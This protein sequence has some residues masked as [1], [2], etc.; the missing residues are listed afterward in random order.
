M[1]KIL[2][3]LLFAVGLFFAASVQTVVN[4]YYQASA[5]ENM[6]RF[7]STMDLSE[8][9]ADDISSM[10]TII[11]KIWDNYDTDYFSIRNFHYTQDGDYA[12]AKYT[13]NASISGAED[14]TY[15]LDYV[16][17]LHYTQG[18]WKVV[19]VKP[20][21]E[22]LDE[23]DNISALLTADA[24]INLS[25]EDYESD[26]SKKEPSFTLD[27]EEMENLDTDLKADLYSCKSD[28]YCQEK[29]WG[30]CENGKCSAPPK[31]ESAGG[32]ESDGVC[33]GSAGLVALAGGASLGRKKKV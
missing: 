15:Q 33:F 28:A 2:L 18:D 11:Q 3:L 16:M 25:Y 8:Y 10:K 7:L 26:V 1:K 30:S 17:L 27:G 31:D 32:E 20:L 24:A 12:L 9:T 13:L 19:W 5:D 14:I 4:N 23:S 6:D 21:Q 29:G 22:Y